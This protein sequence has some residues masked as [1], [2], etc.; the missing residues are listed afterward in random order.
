MSITVQNTTLPN[1]I[2]NPIS[3]YGNGHFSSNIENQAESV[4]L[5]SLQR[6]SEQTALQCYLKFSDF[7]T[8]FA[9]EIF[10]IEG[11]FDIRSDV[12]SVEIAL[13]LNLD[14]QIKLKVILEGDWKKTEPKVG[15]TFHI[16]NFGF[17]LLENFDTPLSV[18]VKS[19]LWAMLGLSSKLKI[20]FPLLNNYFVETRFEL[21]VDEITKLLK[22]RQI[23]YRL[24]VIESTFGIPL[25]FPQGFIDGKDIENIAFCYKAI[26]EREFKWFANPTTIIP[27]QANEES[28]AWLPVS[29]EPTPMIFT[30][31]TVIKSIF[32][33]E[34]PIGIMTGKIDKA[35]ID[36]YDEAKGKLQKLD[37]EIVHIHQRSL[38]GTITMIAVNVPHLP[39]SPWSEKLNKLIDLESNLDEMVFDK[40]LNSFSNAF[41]NLTDEQV[42]VITER[43]NLD[44]EA[45]DF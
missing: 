27:W 35:V 3:F 23:A 13:F 10:D 44:E 2:P 1:I 5:E 12:E 39:K 30:P 24:M 42:K 7:D 37:N 45:F 16:T 31:E 33:I 41:E 19:T 18:F 40:Y 25:P 26:I 34:I 21:S 11:D 17:R 14:N 8:E 15:H 9:F 4:P 43:P 29:K 20:T 28:F 32:G 22:E 36:N 6:F 38:D